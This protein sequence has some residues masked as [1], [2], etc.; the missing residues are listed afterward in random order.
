[1]KKIILILFLINIQIISANTSTKSNTI[2][3]LGD[4]LTEG[5]GVNK[6]EAFP[7]LVETLIKNKL[8]EDITVINGGVSGSTTS[9]GLSRLKWYLKKKPYIVFLAL[10]ANDGLRGLNLESSQKNLEEII[11]HAQEANA[12]VLLAGMLIPPNYGPEYT[13]RFK[14]MYEE[15]KVKYTLES[16][17]FLLKGVAG[18]KELNQRDGIHPNVDGHKYIAKEVF[19]FLKEKL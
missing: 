5:L 13:Q 8:K 11:K 14:K 16:M 18:V 4:S 7:K 17:P 2:L 15:I 9:D 3:F 12:K 6:E 10:G 19:E 1:M